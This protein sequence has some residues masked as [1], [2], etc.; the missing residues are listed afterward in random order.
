MPI[1]APIHTDET[2]LVR[3]LHAGLP[4]LLVFWR[5]DCPPCDQLA[6][7]LD[8]LARSYVG[9]ALVVKVDAGAEPGLLNRYQIS[10]LPSLVFVKDGKTV[11]ATIVEKPIAQIHFDL[12][13]FISLC[14]SPHEKDLSVRIQLIFG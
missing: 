7:A 10:R 6:P 9:K 8:R 11:A 14:A 13:F 4:V 5:R 3:V 12:P 1:D 2:N